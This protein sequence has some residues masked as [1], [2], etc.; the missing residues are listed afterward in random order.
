MWA[1]RFWEESDLE[2]QGCPTQLSSS[3]CP[4]ELARS[5]RTAF[6]CTAPLAFSSSALGVVFI[7]YESEVHANQKHYNLVSYLN[8]VSSNIILSLLSPLLSS[9]NGKVSI[10]TICR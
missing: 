1:R 3:R 7:L 10:V 4:D 9:W 5:Q 8:F 6:G 2:F